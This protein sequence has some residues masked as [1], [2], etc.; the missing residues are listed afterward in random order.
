MGAVQ[1]LSPPLK[2]HGGKSYLAKKIIDLMPP[3][4][5]NPNAPSADDPGWL[6][7]VEP[8]FGGGA[9]LMANSP[10]GIG[11]VVND[12][13]GELTNFWDVL[14]SPTDF[15]ELGEI[16][17]L[18]PCS[19]IEFERACNVP[20]GTGRI[21]RASA[22]F[23]RNRQSRQALGKDFATLAR[24]R[25]RRG[26]NELPSAWLSAIDGL[27]EVHER[28]QRVVILNAP[29]VDV[30]RQQDG[31]R[32]LFYCDPPYMHDTRTVPDAY[33]HE[34]SEED[35]KAL[36]LTLSNIS[37]RFLLSGY[38]SALYDE[39]AKAFNWRRVDFEIDNKAG[40]GKTKRVMIE[41]VW[42][43]Y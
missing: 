15:C 11:E 25:T 10:E 40:G 12:L 4:A 21:E 31:L 7:Y 41:C 23:V 39:F 30:I 27:P 38:R 16:L 28:L 1:T 33:A 29:A 19:Q 35:H 24:T 13:N 43:N 6:H 37:G 14:K 22:F 34:M 3:R 36:L 17:S 20:A 18:T 5:K 9:V 26:M 8:F 32:T 2:W 42:M